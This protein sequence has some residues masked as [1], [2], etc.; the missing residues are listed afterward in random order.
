MTCPP[1]C[2]PLRPPPPPPRTSTT[3]PE[4]NK[5][6][7]LDSPLGTIAGQECFSESTREGA[8]MLTLAIVLVLPHET[9]MAYRKEPL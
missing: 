7:H 4:K 2:S 6:N 8:F 9:A 5:I 3:K 1:Q